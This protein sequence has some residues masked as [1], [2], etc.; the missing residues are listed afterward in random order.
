MLTAA[1][2][3]PPP[4]QWDTSGRILLLPV[5][6]CLLLAF[7]GFWFGVPAAARIVANHLPIASVVS[8]SNE[9]MAALDRDTFTPTELPEH[10]RAS[11]LARF[12]STHWPTASAIPMRIEFRK[13]HSLGAN[14]VALPS[15]LIVVTDD[16]IGLARSDEEILAVL[17]HEAGHVQERHGLRMVLQSSFSALI[18]TWLAG[19][20]GTLATVAP[21]LLLESKYSRDLER[22]AD[23]YAV[24]SLTAN[25]LSPVLLADMLER[26]ATHHGADGSA[27]GPTS[28]LS[29][30]PST[31]ERLHT[32]R[33][34][35]H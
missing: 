11:L 17:A 3:P 29:T 27:S 19:N 10:R 34:A 12:A 8:L 7:A 32:L 5:L 33:Q 21:T 1:A 20:I 9:V 23:A 13:S 2:T 35:T 31:A 16:L 22:A 4:S 6:A 15:G 28:Y 26:M 24:T 18:S 25:Q 14:A 30:H